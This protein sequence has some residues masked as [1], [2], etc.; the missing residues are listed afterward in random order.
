MS[1]NKDYENNHK[2]GSR[3]DLKELKE[4]ILQKKKKLLGKVREPLVSLKLNNLP[5]PKSKKAT[6][7]KRSYEWMKDKNVGVSQPLG[8]LKNFVQAKFMA[9]LG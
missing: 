2:S 8:H 7:L 3:S 9:I 1:T 4:V 5:G 6:S